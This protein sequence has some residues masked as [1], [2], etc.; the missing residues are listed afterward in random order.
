[1]G[2][3][4][5]IWG[6]KV[7]RFGLGETVAYKVEHR[8]ALM[9]ISFNYNFLLKSSNYAMRRLKKA[10]QM[11]SGRHKC[12]SLLAPGSSTFSSAIKVQNVNYETTFYIPDKL[13][14]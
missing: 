12:F 5:S 1:M 10:V 4:I 8:P 6:P 3:K 11:G 2:Y 7:E 9:V 13:V 14:K